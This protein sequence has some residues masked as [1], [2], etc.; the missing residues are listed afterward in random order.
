MDERIIEAVR[1][2]PCLWQVSSRSYK[3]L[4]A[5]ENAWRE[6]A[7]KLGERHSVEECI[8]KWKML[9]DKF[10]RETKNV[11]V[12]KTGEEGPAL[13]VKTSTNFGSTSNA[14]DVA[15]A[16]DKKIDRNDFRERSP[17][18]VQLTPF[19]ISISISCISS[20][21]TSYSSASHS[22][23]SGTSASNK[24]RAKADEIDELLK[25]LTTLQ[26]NKM[27][28]TEECDEDGYFGQ[29]IAA[30]LRRFTPRQKAIAK[31]RMQQILVDTEF[32][33]PISLN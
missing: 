2:F 16:T 21:C 18:D 9:R 6:V 26:D 15:D 8:R 27:S 17:S 28:K 24:R 22:R 1:A 11:K 23:S 33:E 4:K 10:V 7:S 31:L 32:S 5:K 14:T 13:C 29:Q 19:R 3:D 20:I 25:S 12:R 30:T